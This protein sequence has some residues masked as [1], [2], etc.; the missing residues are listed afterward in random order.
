LKREELLSQQ[1]LNISCNNL[2]FVHW[3]IYW[4]WE[5]VLW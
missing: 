5:N 1:I 4:S 2:C 3:C